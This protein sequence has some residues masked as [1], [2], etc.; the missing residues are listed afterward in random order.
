M[1]SITD[2]KGKTVHMIGIGGSSMSGLADMLVK[3]GYTVTGSD[4]T[5]SHAVEGLIEKGVKVYI[6]HDAQNVQGAD[7][8]VYSAAIAADNPERLEAKRLGIPEMERAELLGQLMLGHEINICVSGAH[9]KT[10]TSSMIAEALIDA[11][12]DP[13]V[14]IGGRP[15][16][17]GS[18]SRVGSGKAF[19]AEACEFHGSFLFMHPT[20]AVVLNID[21]DHLDYYGDIEHIEQA[22]EQF[23]N[24]L[25]EG[26]TAVGWGGDERIMRIFSRLNRRKVTFGLT[27][28]CDCFA[29]SLCYTEDGRGDFD[30]VFGGKVLGHVTLT[31]AG[32]F[33]VINALA[34][35][36]ASYVAGAPAEALYRSLSDFAG[37]HRR[38]E[39]TGVTDGVSLYTDYGHNPPEMRAAVHVAVMRHPRRVIAVMQPHT[40][41]RVKT[42]FEGYLTCTEE[43]DITLVTDICAAR[44]K[45]PGDINS[46]MVV[47]GMKKHGVN[48]VYTP[49]FDDTEKYLRDIWQAGDLVITMGCGDINLLNEQIRGHGDSKGKTEK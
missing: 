43:A 10:S 37:V 22:F 13:A 23:L 45:D 28:D 31:T 9:G 7:L 27:P 33:A 44:E 15:I 8:L 4:R 25:P 6:G 1:V 30:I 2:Y 47:E 38:F 18:G 5:L 40:Y 17:L 48:A 14:S 36:A 34:A 11:G 46:L 21:E 20:V 19:V 39:L 35:F 12:M 29:S 3:E 24:L 41:S 32:E 42:L 16:T 26:G 49:T